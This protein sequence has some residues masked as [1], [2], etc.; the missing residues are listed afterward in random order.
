VKPIGYWLN[1]TDRALTASMDRMLAG[2][3][4]TRIG[5][6][7]LN[8]IA[9]ETGTTDAH[10][11]SSL[12]ANADAPTSSAAIDTALADGWAA[13]TASGHL[14][15]TA[16]GRERLA[17]VAARVEEFRRGSIAGISLDEY[18]TAVGVLERMTRNLEG[19]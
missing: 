17:E 9:D 18:R 8:V 7:V 6:Q 4:L 14:H 5:W 16:G 10:V 2:F 13:R 15:L 3:G 1:R 19:A 12:A 11:V